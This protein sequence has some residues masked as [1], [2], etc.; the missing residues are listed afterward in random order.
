ML[1]W[2]RQGFNENQFGPQGHNSR[3]FMGEPAPWTAYRTASTIGDGLNARYSTAQVYGW[4]DGQGNRMR[5]TRIRTP[6]PDDHNAG[7]HAAGHATGPKGGRGEP[8]GGSH[9]GEGTHRHG[10]GQTGIRPSRGQH[11]GQAGSMNRGDRPDF[12]GGS[13]PSRGHYGNQADNMNE[14]D[15]QGLVSIGGQGKHKHRGR[16]WTSGPQGP[17]A[18]GDGGLRHPEERSRRSDW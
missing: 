8:H 1:P 6:L 16:M 5:P 13:R 2:F 17:R 7:H 15:R 11:G 12:H 18:R 9:H 10:N 14:G 3:A 4:D